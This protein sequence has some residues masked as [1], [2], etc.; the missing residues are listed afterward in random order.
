[1]ITCNEA[2]N[3]SEKAV[4]TKPMLVTLNNQDTAGGGPSMTQEASPTGQNPN[5]KMQSLGPP[6]S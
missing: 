4:Y 6:P 2:T 1:M 3:I 5:R